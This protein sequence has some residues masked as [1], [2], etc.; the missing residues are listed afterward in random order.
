MKNFLSNKML[1]K[2]KILNS[3]DLQT[4][5]VHVPEWDGDVMVCSLTGVQRDHFEE[6]IVRKRGK[7]IDVNMHNLR[8]KLVALS[9]V[10]KDG[11][12]IFTD[13]DAIALGKKNA[14]AIQRIYDV[15]AR[16]SGLSKDD[17]EELVKNSGIIPS[18][19]SGSD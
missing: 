17:V 7:N 3:D 8:A 9:V 12:R 5:I 18:D 16:L 19:D 14:S 4:E 2:D 11:S 13:A 10:D 15:A 6:T 1:S